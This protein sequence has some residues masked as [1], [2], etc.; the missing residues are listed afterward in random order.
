MTTNK[1]GLISPFSPRAS[2]YPISPAWSTQP[3]SAVRIMTSQAGTFQNT[4]RVNVI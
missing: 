1:Q 4:S 3:P 2:F